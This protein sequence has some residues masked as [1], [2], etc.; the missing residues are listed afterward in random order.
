MGLDH[1]SRM[2]QKV[3]PNLNPQSP[4][5]LVRAP[6]EVKR[7]PQM[8]KVDKRLPGR[9]NLNSNSHGAKPVH[10]IISTIKWIR[11]SKM[12]IKNSLSLSLSNEGPKGGGTRAPNE[13][14]GP[15]AQRD[16]VVL[17]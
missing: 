14:E 11:T 15:A 4:V 2:L 9:G 16:E 1:Q 5:H 3:S 17:D 7:R 6:H 13:V 8:R 12:P 10:Q